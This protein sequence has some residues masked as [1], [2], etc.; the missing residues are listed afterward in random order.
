MQSHQ[1][2]NRLKRKKSKWETQ[3]EKIGTKLTGLY[4]YRKSG[5]FYA[6]V[7]S[8]GKVYRESL[9]TRDL[10]FA[11]RKLDAFK[12]RLTLTDPS[13]G[14][15]SLVRWLTEVYFPSLRGAPGTLRDKRR[16]IDRIKETW[17]AARGPMRELRP[18]DIERW[19]NQQFGSRS[20]SYHNSAL[21]L[22]RNAFQKA[23][24]DRVVFENPAAQLKYA[25]RT[26]PI[27]LTPTWEQFNQ[28]IADVRA[29]A[30]NAGASDS[31][32]FLE[33]CGLLGLGQ[34]EIRNMLR[35]H[36]DLE[37]GR[38]IVYR[39]KTDVGF[40]IPL[41]PQAASL[42]TRLCAG[43][44]HSSHIFPIAQ[45]RKALRHACKRLGFPNFTTRSLRRMFIVR[46]LE[47][48]INPQVI[49][50]WQG[51]RDG[52]VLILQVY[53]HVRSEHSNRMAQLM[54]VD[55]A[56]NIIKLAETEQSA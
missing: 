54:S 52:G 1:R 25:K 31:G 37:S 42:I 36:I 2:S 41:F 8:G 33:A 13:F 20:M 14:K 44:K 11:K 21:S 40:V 56:T 29:Q 48:G 35:E 16:L 7:K 6:R 50:Q 5:M 15:V 46:A 22:V 30:S 3:W 12:K 9:K 32:D 49:A 17:L 39:C 34:A 4:R 51:H 23:L 28:I 45:S 47:R 55:E 24:A 18:S 43:K 10:I 38:I 27:R 19:L 26:K 53:G